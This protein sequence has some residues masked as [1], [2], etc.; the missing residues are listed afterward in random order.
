M[1][2]NISQH[3]SQSLAQFYQ[4]YVDYCQ[5]KDLRSDY[6]CEGEVVEK[7]EQ[8][9]AKVCGME[10][11]LFYPSGIMA[12]LNAL[13]IWAE[14]SGQTQFGCH[15]SSHLIRHEEDAYRHLLGHSAHLYGS[16]D[17]LPN[18]DDIEKVPSKL[19][20]LF[21]ELPMRHLG[22]DAPEFEQWRKIVSYLNTKNIAL[23]VDGARIFE[24]LPYFN[25]SAQEV[26]AGVDSLFLSFYKGFGSTSGSMLL[27]SKEFIE[28]AKIWRKRFGGN[29]YQIHPLAIGASIGFNSHLNQFN[30]YHLKA[31]EIALELRKLEIEVTPKLIKSNMLHFFIPG[32]ID[33]LREKIKQHPKFNL[34]VGI[35]EAETRGVRFE[36]SCGAATL[37]QDSA[38]IAQVFKE[39]SQ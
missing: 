17:Q 33:Q 6:Y 16:K 24:V 37:E 11:A 20:C 39:L 12:Q 29:L 36:F 26:L 27:G 35:W 10:A 4:K 2:K 14:K 15:E 25:K 32:E 34:K 18:L 7:L 1:K 28:K 5:T 23:H 21:Y 22:G 3:P 38:E 9:V 19:S 30:R 8:Q 31:K 13:L